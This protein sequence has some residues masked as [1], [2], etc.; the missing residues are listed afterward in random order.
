MAG[1]EEGLSNQ[2]SRYLKAVETNVVWFRSGEMY[3]GREPINRPL[4]EQTLYSHR[5]A[6][7][8]TMVDRMCD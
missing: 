8:V 3:P 5:R 6:A 7:A 2:V 1:G 4:Y